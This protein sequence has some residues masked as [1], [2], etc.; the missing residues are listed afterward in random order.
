MESGGLEARRRRIYA[1]VWRFRSLEA[2][3][4]CSDVEVWKSGELEVRYRC[5]W[6]GGMELYSS[7]APEP[8]CKC[9]D[10]EVWRYR[11]LEVLLVRRRGDMEA[12]GTRTDV[13]VAPIE[14]WSARG[15]LRASEARY[16]HASVE[17]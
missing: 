6:C 3:C 7:T 1:E 11:S 12:A 2:R 9:S 8:L 16:R 13:E 14:F 10:V 15:G 5:V 4:S 17:I